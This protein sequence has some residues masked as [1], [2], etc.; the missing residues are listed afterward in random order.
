M[1][2]PKGMTEYGQGACCP[3]EFNHVPNISGN[4]EMDLGIMHCKNK[5]AQAKLSDHIMRDVAYEKNNGY[6]RSSN[7]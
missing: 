3:D 2:Q 5:D 4:H 6:T 7:D 1:K